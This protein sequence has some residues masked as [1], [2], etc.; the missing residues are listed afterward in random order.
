M[1]IADV[2]GDCRTIAVTGATGFIG[3]AVTRKLLGAGW[4]VRALVRPSS[5]RNVPHGSSAELIV[6]TLEDWASL[7]R[8]VEG[9]HAVVHCAGL[10]RGVA[11]A[12]FDD[13]NVHGVERLARVALSQEPTPFF[14]L[15]S[16]L[17]AREPDLSAYAQSKREGE[18]VLA[19]MSGKMSWSALRPPAVYGPGD[20]ALRPLFQCMRWGVAP[21]LGPQDARFSLLYV[22]DLATAVLHWL[23]AGNCESTVFELHDGQDGGYV[24]N[25]VVE[26]AAALLDQRVLRLPIA[27]LALEWM[28]SLSAGLGRL[29]GHAP[30]FTPG[31]VRELRHPN[32]V[33]DNTAL[34]Q[35]T[36]WVP[37]ISFMDGM[38]RTLCLRSDERTRKQ[39]KHKLWN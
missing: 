7:H 24:W 35:A 38:R 18:R 4:R 31:K 20:R 3:S 15:L 34:H 30:I 10:I 13:V 11:A 26:T 39:N 32:W 9:V 29:T 23:D 12:Q 36:G 22:D 17:A 33:C 25:D 27:G 5:V 8:L 28:A 14:L 2:P 21:I 37:R 6:G 16:S 19:T 1:K